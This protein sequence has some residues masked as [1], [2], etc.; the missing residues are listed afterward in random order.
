MENIQGKFRG[1]AFKS[2]LPENS[3]FGFHNLSGFCSF[4]RLLGVL[5]YG[6]L[7]KILIFFSS[8][9]FFSNL[10]LESKFLFAKW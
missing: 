3:D 10:L 5:K 6:F 9:F 4:S 2:A 7:I 1:P 8:F